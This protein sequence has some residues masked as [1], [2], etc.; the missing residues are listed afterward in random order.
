MSGEACLLG[1]IMVNLQILNICE[2]VAVF[3]LD[4][5]FCKHDIFIGLYYIAVF[6]AILF[7]PKIL[8]LLPRFLT[9]FLL[10]FPLYV[11]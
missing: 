4:S 6:I 9:I 1:I 7:F 2:R 10:R 5:E 8:P 11:K 3:V